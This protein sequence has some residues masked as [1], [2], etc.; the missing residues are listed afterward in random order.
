MDWS[1]AHHQSARRADPPAPRLLRT[2]WIVTRPPNKSVT[3]GIYEHVVGHEL[4][5]TYGQ[6][7]H[8]IV[9]TSLSR[10]GDAPL[11]HEAANIRG[12]LEAVGWSATDS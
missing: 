9:S 1:T 7:D 10:T 3:A 12:V 5:V 8:N 6:D 2:L 4:R 11:E